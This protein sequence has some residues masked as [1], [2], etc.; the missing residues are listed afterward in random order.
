MKADVRA[1]GSLLALIL[2]AA[3]CGET[4]RPPTTGTAEPPP[5]AT[6][7]AEPT[8]TVEGARATPPPAW[9]E[10]RRGERWLAFSSYCWSSTCVD[11]QP[12]EQRTDVP[13]IAVQR[14]EVVRFHLGFEPTEATL[15]VGSKTYTLEAQRVTSWRVAG[16]GGFAFLEAKGEPGT[17]SYVARLLVR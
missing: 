1:A 8:P 9:I 16:G 15:R 5:A 12:A 4:S 17:A 11:F 3:A 10:T 6:E 7:P 2:L 13:R 14:D